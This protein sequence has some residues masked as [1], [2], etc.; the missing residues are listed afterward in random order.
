MN[1]PVIRGT[2]TAG[3]VIAFLWSA[4]GTAAAGQVPIDTLLA[5]PTTPGKIGLLAKYRDD[6]RVLPVVKAALTD[7]RADVR[8]AA[9]RVVATSGLAPLTGDARAAFRVERDQEAA[10]ELASAV[11]LNTDGR[12]DSE[13]LEIGRATG[14]QVV[15][16]IATR[17]AWVRAERALGYLDD[18]AR[19]E[20]GHYDSAALAIAT[21]N[22]RA[23][24]ALAKQAL[25]EKNVELWTALLAAI[26]WA[27]RPLDG[28]TI[29]QVLNA[30]TAAFRSEL[31]WALLTMSPFAVKPDDAT[32]SLW[33]SVAQAA[34]EASG[35]PSAD[36]PD[37]R[38]ALA[39]LQRVIG[40]RVTDDPRVMQ[41]LDQP[42]PLIGDRYLG[43]LWLRRDL[44]NPE[45]DA[46]ERR[47]KRLDKD[48]QNTIKMGRGD[49]RAGSAAPA[50]PLRTV[51]GFPG[52]FV[53]DIL[54][55]ADCPSSPDALVAAVRYD[56]RGN[57]ASVNLPAAPSPGNC[58]HVFEALVRALFQD[59]PRLAD[60]Q[61]Q[62]ALLL[63]PDALACLSMPEEIVPP[64]PPAGQD[65]RS[66]ITPPMKTRDVKPMYPKSAIDARLQGI[67]A[68]ESDITTTGCVRALRL[69]GA[70]AP[71]LDL[72]AMIA[73]SQWRFTPTLLDGRPVP[74]KMTVTVQFSLQ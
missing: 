67:V 41:A 56:P 27:R 35:T 50:T 19:L 32:V 9:G 63:L 59:N 23:P 70:V 49:L 71:A 25:R 51:S 64:R 47:A 61:E 73:V 55:V 22:V 43:R 26:D 5:P 65:R 37:A 10:V 13:L 45:R 48:W 3:L 18:L 34:G 52:G 15:R 68:V 12:Y 30:E 16:R 8:A 39:L 28:S 54:K 74:V 44:T 20:D 40:G 21:R 17:L 6:A 69:V 14:Q 31:L 29:R 33:R 66:G 53:A 11:A 38:L 60:P 72:Q 24:D 46:L 62:V 4:G 1:T 42:A 57:L 7:Q 58:H 36:D 2:C